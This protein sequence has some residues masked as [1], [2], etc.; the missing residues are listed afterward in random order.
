MTADCKGLIQLSLPAHS[1]TVT[2][3]PSRSRHFPVTATSARHDSVLSLSEIDPVLCGF[4]IQNGLPDCVR[5]AP[6]LSIF[7]RELKTYLFR[8]SYPHEHY[9]IVCAVFRRHGKPRRSFIYSK[10]AQID[11]HAFTHVPITS[12]RTLRPVRRHKYHVTGVREYMAR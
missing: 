7:D 10:T 4:Q 12:S 6:S 11:A 1:Y 2:D 8:Q 3:S 5:S 9:F